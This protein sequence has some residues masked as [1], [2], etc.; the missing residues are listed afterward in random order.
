MPFE[1]MRVKFGK[2]MNPI[3]VSMKM[4]Q[5]EAS[6]VG[7]FKDES[8]KYFE[9]RFIR[10]TTN[11]IIQERDPQR[12]VIINNPH[13]YKGQFG[14]NSSCFNKKSIECFVCNGWLYKADG[15]FLSGFFFQRIAQTNLFMGSYPLFE[16]DVQKLK[17]AGVNAVLDIKDFMDN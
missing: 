9:Y 4:M 3:Q 11:G 10:K 15:N 5:K 16:M 6:N 1:W 2:P 7:K 17:N 12:Q 8:E 14:A 13:E